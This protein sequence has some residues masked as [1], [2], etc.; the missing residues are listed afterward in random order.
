MIFCASSVVFNDRLPR[1]KLCE[2]FQRI[3]VERLIVAV[4]QF[5][6]ARINLERKNILG[7]QRFKRILVDFLKFCLVNLRS[8]S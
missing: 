5:V 4:I 1:V 8:L 7:F 6:V 3:S 2:V